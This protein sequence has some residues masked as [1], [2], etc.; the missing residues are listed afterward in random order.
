MMNASGSNVLT[1]LSDAMVQAVEKASA[2]T[3]LVNARHRFPATGIVYAAD[4][5]LTANHVVERE[6]GIRVGL[7]D[8]SEVG[9]SL[10]GRDPGSDLALL[11][12]ERAVGVPAEGAPQD[13]RIGQLVLALGR[14]TQEGIQASLG[15]VSAVAGPVRTERGGVLEKYV[16]TDAIPYP[17]FSGG[18]LVDG[19]GRILGV[20]TSGFAPG[21]SLTIPV[22]L[23]WSVADTLSKHGKVRRGY[24]GIR[25][26]PVEIPAAAV[27]KLGRTQKVGLL[28][29][30]IEQD[31]AAA[32]DGLMVG[33]IIVGVAGQ[34]VENHD[35]LLSHLGTDTVGKPVAMEV[36]RGGDVRTVNLTVG[37]RS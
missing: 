5:V 22:S 15:V 31:S 8:G 36:V 20:N 16:R 13:A 6:D 24:L 27:G 34:T 4:L 3:V 35:D 26:Q 2:S 11:R 29:V 25:S 10:A 30:G 9:A 14:P 17:G 23:A 19:E 18:P 37:E 7:P 21:A 33:D 32:R 1:A 12:L 28:L